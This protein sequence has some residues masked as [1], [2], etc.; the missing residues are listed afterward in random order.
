M[1]NHL[2]SEQ[3]QRRRFLRPTEYHHPVRFRSLPPPQLPPCCQGHHGAAKRLLHPDRLRL[4]QI[5]FR[6]T[7]SPL[8]NPGIRHRRRLVWSFP[9]YPNQTLTNLIPHRQQAALNLYAEAR[10]ICPSYWLGNAYESDSLNS[11]SPRKAWR[12]Q[13][14]VPEAFHSLD[15]TPLQKNPNNVSA[16]LNLPFDGT[17]ARG[18]QQIWG[19]FVTTG[20]PTLPV[21]GGLGELAAA[22][23]DSWVSWGEVVGKRGSG[24]LNSRGYAML[25]LNA[26]A[27][28]KTEWTVADGLAWEG[29]R[30]ERCDLWARIGVS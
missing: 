9:F 28:G 15:L 8:R 13:F 14:S 19:R 11:N 20:D 26:T 29:G 23:K 22:G 1:S 3:C 6:R 2:I 30:W 27:E 17:F 7:A 5:Q 12:Y 16:S 18:F 10:F 4:S 25:N 21:D 24:T